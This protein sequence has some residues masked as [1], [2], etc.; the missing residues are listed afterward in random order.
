MT[1]KEI[2]NC[3]EYRLQRLKELTGENYALDW[4]HGIV[5]LQVIDER[6]V[7]HH[8]KFGNAN[9]RKT[10]SEMLAYLDGLL[11]GLTGIKY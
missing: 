3:L 5:A 6:H 7:S 2:K 9:I 4:Y 10:A 11:S 8:G 1:T